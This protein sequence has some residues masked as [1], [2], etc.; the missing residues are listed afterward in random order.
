MYTMYITYNLRLYN[1]E[2]LRHTHIP[3]FHYGSYLTTDRPTFSANGK[4]S[5]FPRLLLTWP[6]RHPIMQYTHDTLVI[7]SWFTCDIHPHPSKK[8]FMK[9]NI[10]GLHKI[11]LIYIYIQI[12]NIHHQWTFIAL[13]TTS[14]HKKSRGKTL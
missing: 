7:H 13:H 3:S 6:L 2:I 12:S 14:R 9:Y 4:A 5:F 1:V 10:F 8:M 11:K